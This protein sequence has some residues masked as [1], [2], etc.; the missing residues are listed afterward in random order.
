VMLV[1]DGV[2]VPFSTLLSFQQTSPESCDHQ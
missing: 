2:N 1:S